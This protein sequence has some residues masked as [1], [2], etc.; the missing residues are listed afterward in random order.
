VALK[1]SKVSGVERQKAAEREF[2]LLDGM[3]HPGIH[4][5]EQFTEHEHGPALVFEHD[6]S[7]ERM[8]LFLQHRGKEIDSG[9][10]PARS[11]EELHQKLS[12]GR[13][14]RISDVL[15]GGRARRQTRR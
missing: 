10:P 8:D 12:S 2:Q 3:V 5:V 1:S 4:R 6:P 15:D 14:L 9:E 13:G 7:A 11:V